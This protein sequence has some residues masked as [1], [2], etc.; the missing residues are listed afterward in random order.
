MLD[1]RLRNESLSSDEL[2]KY[3][4]I[5]DIITQ[6]EIKPL[7]MVS[8]ENTH[9]G[10]SLISDGRK[11]AKQQ[12]QECIADMEYTRKKEQMKKE[13]QTDI[14]HI[15]YLDYQIKRLYELFDKDE[16]FKRENFDKIKSF[17]M[18]KSTK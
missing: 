2:N 4:S 13:E 3:N 12:C 9:V 10:K 16:T 8:I 7:K 6:K 11:T 17:L 1:S 18:E 14:Y 15:F 5:D